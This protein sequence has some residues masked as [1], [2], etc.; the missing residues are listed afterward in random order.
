MNT[1]KLLIPCGY[2]VEQHNET[3]DITTAGQILSSRKQRRYSWAIRHEW[4]A[5]LTRHVWVCPHCNAHI[6]AYPEYFGKR[7]SFEKT[8][9]PVVADWATLQL[10]LFEEPDKELHFNAPFQSGKMV[11]PKCMRESERNPRSK[12]L[13]FSKKKHYLEISLELN[14]L[15]DIFSLNWMSNSWLNLSFPVYE[16]VVFNL[17]NGHTFLK[18]H[19]GRGTNYTVSDITQRPNSWCNGPLY[20]VLDNN[21]VASRT[22]KRIFADIFGGTLPFT[23]AELT[24]DKYVLMCRFLG[25][26][27]RF[28][29]AI[30]FTDNSRCIDGSFK[31]VAKRLHNSY[32]VPTIYRESSL[33]NAKT[34]RKIFF[35][36][37]GLFFYIKECER[38]WEILNDVN[39]FRE[40]ISS[41]S[42]YEI[43]S[44]FHLFPGAMT[45]FSD[46]SKFKGARSLLKRLEDNLYETNLE[47]VMYGNLNDSAKKKER[48]NWKKGST[49][50]TSFEDEDEYDDEYYSP[51][52]PQPVKY[53]TPFAKTDSMIA[54]C[55]IDG[56]SFT[57]LSSSVDYFETGSAL[58]NCLRS[59]SRFNNP[60]V[61]VKDH[62]KIIAAIEVDIVRRIVVQ[63]RTANNRLIETESKLGNAYE[64]LKKRYSVEERGYGYIVDDD[65][66]L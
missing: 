2:N 12:N 64:K 65:L 66:P 7:S 31:H 38:F 32:N 24:L 18:L 43:L 45:F 41:D 26:S 46:Y 61:V 4:Q 14:E 33:P 49:G 9:R 47:A 36:D 42:I 21:K 25:Y 17:R 10:S 6:P 15:K 59:W 62:N 48:A 40:L 63:A 27:R 35:E 20:A 51:R 50:R 8:E 22:L 52:L 34:V 58:H 28:Y 57:W 30:P 37:T 13:V 5:N 11:C 60:V 16:S 56:F 29:D 55:C 54:P 19:D 53:S 1:Q 39:L 44:Q 23:G 3:V